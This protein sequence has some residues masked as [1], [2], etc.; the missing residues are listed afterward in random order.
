MDFLH[1]VICML[2]A[3]NFGD[4]ISEACQVQEPFS[5]EINKSCLKK[6][7]GYILSKIKKINHMIFFLK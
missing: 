5:N 2:T 4:G 1:G 3:D 6:Q 7:I